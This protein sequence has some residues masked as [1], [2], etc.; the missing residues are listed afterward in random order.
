MALIE[1]KFFRKT[2]GTHFFDYNT[3]EKFLEDLKLE[4]VDEK[5]RRH[6]SNWLRHVTR[7]D[8]SRMAEVMLSWR[9]N[10][11]RGIGRPLKRQLDKAETGLSRPNW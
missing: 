6:K 2:A 8:S 7:M 11:R 4:P 1:M 9:P 3:N 10:G 5:L